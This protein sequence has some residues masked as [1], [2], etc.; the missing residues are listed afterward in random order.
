MRT[1]QILDR[2]LEEVAAYQRHHKV[3][4]IAGQQNSKLL[5]RDEGRVEQ[6]GEARQ[7]RCSRVRSVYEQHDPDPL[8][9]C[10][11]RFRVSQCRIQ[12]WLSV[13]VPL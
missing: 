12:L 4:Q 3:W 7:S 9:V 11:T 1:S 2:V 8:I 13:Y 5:L 10:M 6:G